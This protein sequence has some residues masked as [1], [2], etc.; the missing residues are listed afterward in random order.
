MNEKKEL[1]E[2]E[3]ENVSGGISNNTP[4]YVI[5]GVPLDINNIN[6]SDIA[7]IDVLKDASSTAIYGSAGAS[8]VIKYTEKKSR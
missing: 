5:D 2:K 7:S 4:L 6:P 8:P 3:L 1:L